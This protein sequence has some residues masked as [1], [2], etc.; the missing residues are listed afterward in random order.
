MIKYNKLIPIQIGNYIFN[1]LNSEVEDNT[2]KKTQ[3]DQPLSING[4][5]RNNNY[6]ADYLTANTI[7]FSFYLDQKDNLH[8]VKKMAFGQ[9]IQKIWFIERY[10]NKPYI[11][12]NNDATD[13]YNIYYAYGNI[14][15]ISPTKHSEQKGQT[16]FDI[17]DLEFKISGQPTKYL[18]Q[19]DD[20]YFI[21][22]ELLGTHQNVFQSNNYN[23]Q[24]NIFDFGSIGGFPKVLKFNKLDRYE[25]NLLINERCCKQLGFFF[26]L[27]RFLKLDRLDINL[28]APVYNSIIDTQQNIPYIFKPQKINQVSS[29]LNVINAIQI[30]GLDAGGVQLANA[31]Q[32]NTS[33]TV[34]NFS[35]GTKFK[36]TCKTNKCPKNL[37][38]LP[39]KSM[40]LYDLDNSKVIDIYDYNSSEYNYFTIENQG[41]S[42]HLFSFSARVPLID[43]ETNQYDDLAITTNFFGKTK[44]TISTLPSFY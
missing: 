18:A 19:G 4:D 37:I 38:I 15:K 30:Q 40:I 7:N 44:I 25:K 17:Y 10:N 31:M 41:T 1:R 23:F 33:F 28:S 29:A 16:K 11:G 26:Q 20:L 13:D 9:G 5:V 36:I 2:G 32:P 8:K 43:F 6:S 34:E 3:Y 24:N 35:T 39:H 12:V 21:P 14:I 27:D 22:Y 42:P